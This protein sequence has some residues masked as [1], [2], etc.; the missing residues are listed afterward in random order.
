MTLLTMAPLVLLALALLCLTPAL[1]ENTPPEV[2]LDT[3]QEGALLGVTA[4]VSG[5]ATDGEGFN[6][7]SLVEA[8]WNDW[9][10]FTLPSNPGGDGRL[11]HFG[12]TVDLSWHAPGEH[13]LIVRAYDGELWSEEVNI[14]VTVRDLPDLVVLPSD[15]TIDPEDAVAGDDA[16]VVVRVQNQGGEDVSDVRVVLRRG[17]VELARETIEEV[18]A[19]G[20]SEVRFEFELEEGN[21]TLSV[22]VNA[23]GQLME[24]SQ[25]NNNAERTFVI[26]ADT[27][28]MSV[29]QLFL[30][31]AIVVVFFLLVFGALGR[32]G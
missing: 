13:R 10:W 19:Q 3:P 23:L 26:E 21:L 22:T 7:S 18:P 11:L 27:G 15:I 12:E 4:T 24:R 20:S 14:T 8:R 6:V 2:D 30:L 1:A 31:I 17:D 16:E 25:T 32:K 5:K 9:E 28:E 29:Q